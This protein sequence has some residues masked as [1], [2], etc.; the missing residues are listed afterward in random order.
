[1]PLTI[2]AKPAN[3]EK[4]VAPNL[5]RQA[6]KCRRGVRNVVASLQYSSEKFRNE[7]GGFRAEL[8]VPYPRTQMK[9]KRVLRVDRRFKL[10]GAWRLNRLYR[11][12]DSVERASSRLKTRF[13]LCQLRTRGLKHSH[14]HP[15][16]LDHDVDKRPILNSP[17]PRRHDA[18]T[19]Q[20][21]EIDKRRM[22]LQEDG[23]PFARV[24]IV[25]Q[26]NTLSGR[27]ARSQ[28]AQQSQLQH[29]APLLRSISRA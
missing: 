19:G 29:V 9:G 10:Y 27:A 24:L 5:L 16:L 6:L 18:V 25:G 12:W 20:P 13:G 15:S 26:Q 3:N 17:R 23:A 4:K 11:N 2:I 14:P 8:I 1:M 7:V 21:H 22:I 28:Q